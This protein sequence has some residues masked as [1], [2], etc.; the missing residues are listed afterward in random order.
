MIGAAKQNPNQ[1]QYGQTREEGVYCI[2]NIIINIV[3]AL[4]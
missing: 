4:L 2:S 1:I 3:H